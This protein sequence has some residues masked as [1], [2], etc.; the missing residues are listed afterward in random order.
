[1]DGFSLQ[2]RH[3]FRVGTPV[4][5]RIQT[6]VDPAGVNKVREFNTDHGNTWDG[7]LDL[8]VARVVVGLRVGKWSHGHGGSDRTEAGS[9][10]A[11]HN[12]LNGW[13]EISSLPY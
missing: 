9:E 1:M 10:G 5:L 13:I 6:H 8:V 12:K 3:G 7:P 11:H 4:D 2:H